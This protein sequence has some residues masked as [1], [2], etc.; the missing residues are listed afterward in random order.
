MDDVQ[1]YGEHRRED[2]LRKYVLEEKH[3]LCV[4]TARMASARSETKS[5]ALKLRCFAM[6][7]AE[8]FKTA[9]SKSSHF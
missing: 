6:S 8:I 3:L 5:S 1:G 7:L 2:R 4:G 9:P